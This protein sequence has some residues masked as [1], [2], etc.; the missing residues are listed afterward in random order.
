MTNPDKILTGICILAVAW[1]LAVWIGYQQAITMPYVPVMPRGEILP[2]LNAQIDGAASTTNVLLTE[3]S[4]PESFAPN[5]IYV[6]DKT[7]YRFTNQIVC[8]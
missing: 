4:T 6:K 1:C 8:Q 5:P 2:T 3:T 7:C